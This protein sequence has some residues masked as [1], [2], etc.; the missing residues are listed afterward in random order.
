MTKNDHSLK[1][2]LKKIAKNSADF[3]AKNL[4]FYTFDNM[5]RNNLTSQKVDKEPFRLKTKTSFTRFGIYLQ[6][7]RQVL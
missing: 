6:N 1:Q 3:N 7:I 5:I 4:R 2:V